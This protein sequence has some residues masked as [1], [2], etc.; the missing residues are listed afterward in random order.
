MNLIP[1]IEFIVGWGRF[2][3]WLFILA[4]PF[5]LLF[6]VFRKRLSWAFFF[7]TLSGV[8]LLGGLIGVFTHSSAVSKL[9]PVLAGPV[10]KRLVVPFTQ[11][12]D[13]KPGSLDTWSGKVVL[14][15]FRAS[16]NDDARPPMRDLEQ[17]LAEL[18]GSDLVVVALSDEPKDVLLA[19]PQVPQGVVQGTFELEA[20]PESLRGHAVMRPVSVL[21]DRQ[22]IVRDVFVGKQTSTFL[23]REL[24]EYL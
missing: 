2:T 1:L 22:G 3:S 6:G 5:V 20:L 13:G 24:R 8:M 19:Q 17:V 15:Q 16:W 18:G 4:S 10:G 7:M 11:L 23:A 14:L 21:I 12:V 9:A